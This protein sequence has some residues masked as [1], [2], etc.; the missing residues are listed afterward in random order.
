MRQVIRHYQPDR[1]R[2][3]VDTTSQSFC[4]AYANQPDPSVPQITYGHSKNLRPDLKQLLFGVGRT[5]DGLLL[6]G[7]VSSGNQ[8]DMTFNGHWIKQVREQLALGVDEFLLSIADSAVQGWHSEA[9]LAGAVYRFL[10]VASSTLDQR[11]LKALER[12]IAREVTRSEKL[13]KRAAGQSFSERSAAETALNAL[14]RSWSAS[15]HHLQGQ[16]ESFEHRPPRPRRG[17]PRAGEV[18]PTATYYRIR[19]ALVPDETAQQQARDRCG[20]FV[21]IT[22]LLDRRQDPARHLLDT[23]TGQHTAEQ[24][25]RFIKSPAWVGRS[26]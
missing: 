21:L 23:Y 2:L 26:A 18:P 17:R 5:D 14:L 1:R 25:M 12:A 9:E 20:L 15:Y 24:A 6:V 7:E 22:S 11:H 4:G 13:A 8:S 16:I 19:L 10:V 3:H